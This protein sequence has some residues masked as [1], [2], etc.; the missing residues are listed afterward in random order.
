ENQVIGSVGKFEATPQGRTTLPLLIKKDYSKQL[1]SK[2]R[3]VIQPDPFIPGHEAVNVVQLS[4]G[5]TPLPPQ[6]VVEGSTPSSVAAEK[7][8]GGAAAWQG[9]SSI[10]N[11]VFA[12]L[13]KQIQQLPLEQWRKELE[14][15]LDSLNKDL[16]KSGTE[17][18]KKFQREVLPQIEQAVNDLMRRL[19]ELGKESEGEPVQKKLDELE[20]SLNK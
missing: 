4:S 11:D 1:T 13:Q 15:Q 6:A 7:G 12:I 18:Q 19:K 3:F 9:W 16:Q 8:T 20:R 2:S 14:R 10:V 17:V 5:G